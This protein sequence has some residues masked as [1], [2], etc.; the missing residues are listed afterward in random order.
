M[1]W[2]NEARGSAHAHVLEIRKQLEDFHAGLAR[3][4]EVDAK[5]PVTVALLTKTRPVPDAA[6]TAKYQR[7]YRRLEK[8]ITAINKA[9]KRYAFRPAI[10]Y[11]ITSDAR[12]GGLVP[13]VDKRTFKL[14]FGDWELVGADAALALVRLFLKGELQRVQ[15]CE[16]CKQ[17]WVD[18]AKSHYKFCS[19]EC[20]E[21]YYAEAPGYAKRKA[22]NQARYREHKKRAEVAGLA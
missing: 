12:G 6:Y 8:E 14:S 7:E 11:V 4:R 17:R 1:R 13:D 10:G 2:L 9:L 16:M 21:G 5:N 19:G 22:D 18:R 20:R 3:F 15:L